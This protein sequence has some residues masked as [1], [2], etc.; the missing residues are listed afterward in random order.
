MLRRTV[1][2]CSSI[3]RKTP[4]NRA[5]SKRNKNQSQPVHGDRF[6]GRASM[7]NDKIIARAALAGLLLLVIL[8]FTAVAG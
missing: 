5:C 1:E 7:A 4:G 2:R 3:E 8:S 6:T